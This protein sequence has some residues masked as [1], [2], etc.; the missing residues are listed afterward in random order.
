MKKPTHEECFAALKLIEQLYKE[1]HISQLMFRNV[2]SEYSDI[3][4][5]TQFCLQRKD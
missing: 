3:V 5:I 4:D 1:G 2:L